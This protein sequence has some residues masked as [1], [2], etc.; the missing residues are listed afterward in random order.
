MRSGPGGF[1][2]VATA[3]G[4]PA[5]PDWLDGQGK[6]RYL[7]LMGEAT[8]CWRAPSFCFVIPWVVECAWGSLAPRNVCHGAVEAGDPPIGKV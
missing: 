4:G 1:D 6:A 2:G 5:P 8:L 7:A 3:V